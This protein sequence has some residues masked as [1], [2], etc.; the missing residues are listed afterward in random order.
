MTAAVP[1]R[2][3]RLADAFLALTEPAIPKGAWL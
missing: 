2:V 1:A 3:S